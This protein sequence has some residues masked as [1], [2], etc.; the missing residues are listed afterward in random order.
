MADAAVSKASQQAVSRPNRPLVC[1]PGI[2]S[3]PFRSPKSS[4]PRKPAWGESSFRAQKSRAF[5]QL[6]RLRRS[7]R[8]KGLISAGKPARNHLDAENCPL[9]ECVWAAVGCKTRT[10]EPIRMTGSGEPAQILRP[11]PHGFPQ[12]D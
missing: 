8:L 12:C 3:Y 2:V 4:K 10:W 1:L 9:S 5:H 11:L 6:I 7:G